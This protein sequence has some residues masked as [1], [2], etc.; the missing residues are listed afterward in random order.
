VKLKK[1][2]QS[3]IS[4]VGAARD[5]EQ[6]QL[7]ERMADDNERVQREAAMKTLFYSSFRIHSKGMLK[8]SFRAWTS[9]VGAARDKDHEQQVATLLDEKGEVQR[10]AAIKTVWYGVRRM[11]NRVS[12]RRSFGVWAAA[13]RAFR[14]KQVSVRVPNFSSRPRLPFFLRSLRLQLATKTLWASYTRVGA[15]LK[16]R[17]WSRWQS[18]IIAVTSIVGS[19]ATFDRVFR[20][21]KRLDDMRQAMDALS[22]WTRTI[23]ALRRSVTLGKKGEMGR[24]VSQ[25]RLFVFGHRRNDVKASAAKVVVKGLQ[26]MLLGAIRTCFQQWHS[27]V[28]RQNKFVG[29]FSWLR[30]S[31]EKK[32]VA[33][34]MRFWISYVYRMREEQVQMLHSYSNVKTTMLLCR[35]VLERVYLEKLR[36]AYTTWLR[37]IKKESKKL[38]LRLVKKSE[39]GNVCLAFVR[40]MKYVRERNERKTRCCGHPRE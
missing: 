12:V 29:S 28:D 5:A 37:E 40:W 20:K 4:R 23:H 27:V 25:W 30:V 6:Q 9:L 24:A 32:M 1:S 18:R 17:A 15:E 34:A 39:T 14:D 13:V 35:K 22:S 16:R 31:W 26:K 38:I 7:V 10:E 19:L 8:L 2:F 21:R 11:H 36:E 3:W 33:T